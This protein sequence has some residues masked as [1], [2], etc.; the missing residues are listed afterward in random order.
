MLNSEESDLMDEASSQTAAILETSPA[1]SCSSALA[2]P[3]Q[4]DS[5]IDP[6]TLTDQNYLAWKIQ[7]F[8]HFRRLRSIVCQMEN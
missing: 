7:I 8:F 4:V 6:I 3:A 5:L 1:A 2:N